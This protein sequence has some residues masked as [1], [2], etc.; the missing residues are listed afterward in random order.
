MAFKHENLKK[1]KELFECADNLYHLIDTLLIVFNQSSNNFRPSRIPKYKNTFLYLFNTSIRHYKSIDLLCQEGH[2]MSALILMRSLLENLITTK[3]IILNK[4]PN[5]L[6]Q[7]FEEYKW[8]LM[9][10][11]LKYWKT[12]KQV[13]SKKLQKSILSKEPEILAKVKEYKVNFKVKNGLSTWSGKSVERMAEVVGMSNEYNLVYRMCCLIS[14]PS[15]LGIIQEVKRTEEYT[16]FSSDPSYCNIITNMIL[17]IEYMHTF[18]S[19]Y[20]DLFELGKKQELDLFLKK[21]K[22]GF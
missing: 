5:E 19:V 9:R 13:E 17:T 12:N 6:A 11:Q 16:Y 1:N 7:R 15:M 4:N 20:N 14:H 18:L 8:L 22:V 3:Y 10:K 2:G 21:Y